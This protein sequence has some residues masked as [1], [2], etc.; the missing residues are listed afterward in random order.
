MP[1][2]ASARRLS[3]AHRTHGKALDPLLVVPPNPA[4]L[5]FVPAERRAAA[6]V[7]PRSSTTC[8]RPSDQADVG[9]HNQ[10]DRVQ[11]ARRTTR[12]PRRLLPQ[13]S[14]GPP[15]PSR[16]WPN[17]NA[18]AAAS[19]R[20]VLHQRGHGPTEAA[21]ARQG[22]Q[23]LGTSRAVAQRQT[24][25]ASTTRRAPPS[26]APSARASPAPSPW[27]SRTRRTWPT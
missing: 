11:T 27:C 13:P 8:R 20:L 23:R 14:H 1:V 21:A 2:R 22:E 12:R 5:E 7:T 26:T 10:M 4:E 18:G 25:E 17:R 16:T 24:I 3:S 6:A 19:I 9:S 15:R